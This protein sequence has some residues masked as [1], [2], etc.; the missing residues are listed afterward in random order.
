MRIAIDCRL[1]SYKRAEEFFFG[2]AVVPALLDLK[3]NHHYYLIFD[4]APSFPFTYQNVT[5]LVLKPAA[6]SATSRPFWYDFR[7][8]S[9]LL[10]HKIDLFLGLAGY[11]SL[12]SSV[13]QILL[14]HDVLSGQKLPDFTGWSSIWYKRRL[15]AM[16]AKAARSMVPAISS[17]NIFFKNII[18]ADFSVL[19]GCTIWPSSF[20]HN[21]VDSRKV[22]TEITGGPE[23]LLCAA[24]W[25]SMKEAL[26]LLLA[27]SAFKKRQQTGMKLLLYGEAPK[28]KEWIEK[29][30]TYRYH[31]DVI[32]RDK[33][34]SSEDF[35]PILCASY[36]LL[37]LSATPKPALIQQA[38]TLGVPVISRPLLPVREIAG[39]AI[40]YITDAP[41]ET[42]AQQM[43]QLYKDEKL[44]ASIISKGKTIAR[45]WEPGY[46][47]E[48]LLKICLAC[49]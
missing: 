29:L 17:A 21:D 49:H 11:I 24:G 18:P 38:L 14:L 10:E 5:L 22:K 37:H 33:N 44:R 35:Y 6:T 13:T 47:A 8:P 40:L 20:N 23:F 4:A 7:L 45:E 36:G 19:P 46:V 1:W 25:Q 30:R 9:L 34:L 28:E 26:D 12:R 3:E 16:L 2:A 15:P 39:D 32:V 43:M 27:F 48:M 42:L 31:N 41:G